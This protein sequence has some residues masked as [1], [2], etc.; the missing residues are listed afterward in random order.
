MKFCSE[1]GTLLIPKKDKA[2]G[3]ISIICRKCGTEFPPDA[4]DLEEYRLSFNSG[5]ASHDRI[6][7][8][9]E[10][11]QKAKLVT[12]EDREAYEDFFKETEEL[13]EEDSGAES[14]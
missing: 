3:E 5:T 2:S 14:T 11:S 1:C 6:A 8:I 4:S 12:D 10:H 13:P 7:I 9:K